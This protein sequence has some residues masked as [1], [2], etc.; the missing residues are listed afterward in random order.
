MQDSSTSQL[1]FRLPK[2]IAWISRF[3]TLVP[4]DILL[5]GTP[6]GVGVFRKPPVFLKVRERQGETRNR[7]GMAARG[8]K[9]RGDRASHCVSAP[10][11]EETRC[12]A[13]SRSWA[14][15]ATRW[16]EDR[17]AKS[18]P[19]SAALTAPRCNKSTSWVGTCSQVYWQWQLL[20][21]LALVATAGTNCCMKAC[22]LARLPLEWKGWARQSRGPA[23][24]HTSS[25]TWGG[26][27]ASLE[28]GEGKTRG[29]SLCW[30]GRWEGGKGA[31]LG[32][33]GGR[34][35]RAGSTRSHLPP[36]P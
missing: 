35:G 4:G 29:A 19:D 26:R 23:G 6:P 33:E 12:S 15:S 5:T 11:R 1:I 16:C 7:V 2:L 9:G 3:V 31:S 13:R 28:G 22:S 14:P 20:V 30:G 10:C 25:S 27:G 17:D 18:H 24:V 34:E 32:G 21:L 36:S 8:H